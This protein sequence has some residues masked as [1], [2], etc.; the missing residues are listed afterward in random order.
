M[1]EPKRLIERAAADARIL[2]RDESQRIVERV[3]GLSKADDAQVQLQTSLTGNTRFAAN[4]LS[5]SGMVQDVTL[6]VTSAFGK[7]S[8]AVSTN[9]LSDA[10]V[11]RAVEASE[12]MARLAP[13]DPEAMPSL[14]AQQYEPVAAYSE[15]TAALGPAERA[16]ACHDALRLARE[17]GDLTAAGFLVTQAQSNALGNKFGLF[18]YFPSTSATYTV[19]VRTADG[20]GS[21]WAGADAKDWKALDVRGASARAVEKARLSREPVAIEPGRYTVILE[22][23]AVA[24]LVQV[25]LFAMNARQADEGRSPFVKP[26]G[27][28]KIGERI[29]DQRVTLVSD[30]TDPLLLAQPFD[31]EGFPLRRQTWIEDGVLKALFYTRYW[32]R[33]QQARATGFPTSVK[34]QGGSTSVDEM[35]RATPRGLLVTR[36][37]YLR[38]VDPRTLLYT[39]LT[40]DGLFLVENGKVSK[41]VRNFRFNE[42][43]LFMLN[44]VEAIGPAVR[45]AGTEAGGDVA[46]PA[47]KVRDFNFTSLSEAV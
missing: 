21:G 1:S 36:L 44:N 45:V 12:A 22:A 29:V 41:A 10:S 46:M 18:A 23:Q 28:N 16:D 27:G 24:D 25:M 4:Q 15:P 13:E 42:S 31:F 14:P 6:T 9:D 37:F 47:L 7:R 8:A 33:K 2:S 19:T 3:L 34:L 26:S 43:P 35:I 20:T 11:R 40:R 38:P 5:T 30:P 32:A 39:G 17:A